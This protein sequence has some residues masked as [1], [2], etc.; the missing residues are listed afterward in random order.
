MAKHKDSVMKSAMLGVQPTRDTFILPSDVYNLAKKRAQELYE[1]HKVDAVS[2]RMWAEEN[3]DSVFFFQ[4]HGSID[5]NEA[6]RPECT[7]TLGI[8][9]DWQLQVMAKFG[10][11]SAVSFGATFGTNTPRVRKFSTAQTFETMP[12]SLD[13]VLQTLFRPFF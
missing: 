9:T 6:P 10:D 7:Y 3:T 11:R 13:S 4:E 5:L 2:V 8:K 12:L 1:K